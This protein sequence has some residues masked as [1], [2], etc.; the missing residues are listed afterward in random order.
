MLPADEAVFDALGECFKEIAQ[1]FPYSPYIHIGGDEAK[2]DGWESC[3]KTQRYCAAHNIDGLPAS[4]RALRA[5]LCQN[6]P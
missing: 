3:E 2:I 4:I 1:L 5:A 6:G